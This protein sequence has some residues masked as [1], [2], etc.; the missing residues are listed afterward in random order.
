MEHDD[1]VAKPY[2]VWVFI[3]VVLLLGMAH[4]VLSAETGDD[5]DY[6]LQQKLDNIEIMTE[7]IAR[8]R[9]SADELYRKLSA[10]RETFAEEIVT[11]ARRVR[12]PSFKL[13]QSDPR[14]AYNVKLVGRLDAYLDALGKRISE[15]DAGSHRL[16][17]LRAKAVD[18]LKLVETFAVPAV[19]RLIA[20][21]DGALE[22]YHFAT[23]APLFDVNKVTVPSGQAVW[24]AVVRKK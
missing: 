18:D 13:A 6:L 15:F 5:V 14:I 1:R 9:R 11:E 3:L 23:T 17:Y 20:D 10:E 24:D 22:Q 19:D 12:A 8:Q 2:P 7:K 21:I 16:G 4:K